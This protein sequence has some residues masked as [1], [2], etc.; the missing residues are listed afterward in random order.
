MPGMMVERRRC[1]GRSGTHM[2]EGCFGIACD[3]NPMATTAIWIREGHPA[4][5]ARNLP[6][7]RPSCCL[8]LMG[9]K[10]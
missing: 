3:G 1:G 2:A 8:L 4:V 7:T 5:G 6:S 10:T 9:K